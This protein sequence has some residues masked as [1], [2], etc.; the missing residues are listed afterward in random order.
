MKLSTTSKK[1]NKLL[2]SN[3]LV[4]AL[5][6]QQTAASALAQNRAQRLLS[7]QAVT[8]TPQVHRLLQ[9][10]EQQNT[11]GTTN[12]GS[13]TEAG[14]N[15]ENGGNTENAGSTTENT[16]A[17]TTTENTNKIAGYTIKE[18]E[19][20]KWCNKFKKREDLV[21]SETEFTKEIKTVDEKFL[22]TDILKNLFKIVSKQI[23]KGA[24]DP[25]AFKEDG[26]EFGKKAWWLSIN[27]IFAV[28]SALFFVI[29]LLYFTIK[30]F[31]GFFYVIFCC[32]CCPSEL[33][34]DLSIKATDDQ[35]ERVRKA[36]LK[37][38][39]EQRI[40]SLSNP[41]CNCFIAVTSTLI[42]TSIIVLGFFWHQNVTKSLEGVNKTDCMFNLAVSDLRHG[43]KTSDTTF[44]GIG[45]VQYAFGKLEE[46]LK[47]ITTPNTLQQKVK[48]SDV[49]NLFDSLKAYYNDVKGES[50]PSAA[51]NN[52]QVVPDIVFIQNHLILPYIGAEAN[53]LGSA[54]KEIDTMAGKLNE[55][56][57][58]NADQ[59][60]T[61]ITALLKEINKIDKEIEKALDNYKEHAKINDH[62]AQRELIILA[63]VSSIAIV[64]IL[65]L[66]MMILSL[67]NK[68]T[69]YLVIFEAILSLVKMLLA[70][71]LNLLAFA[72]LVSA[73]LMINGCVI[74]KQNLDQTTSI[75]E[76]F[77]EPIVTKIV[78]TC[79]AADGSGN[80]NNIV[81]LSTADKGI[82]QLNQVVDALNINL[83]A[84]NITT[85]ES[86]SLTVYK[87]HLEKLRTFELPAFTQN[88]DDSPEKL[89]QRV[90][91][92][93]S[94]DCVK[95][96]WSVFAGR[97]PE[98][99]PASTTTSQV[100][101]KL[102]ENFCI[103]TTPLGWNTNLNQRY[104]PNWGANPACVGQAVDTQFKTLLVCTT[105]TEALMAKLSAKVDE[106]GGPKE[107]F[108]TVYGGLK[109]GETEFKELRAK[110]EDTI[111]F[112]N[113]LQ[114]DLK[115]SLN[116]KIIRTQLTNLVGNACVKFGK[117][118]VIQAIFLAAIGPLMTILSCCICCTFVQS[119]EKKCLDELKQAQIAD[120]TA[121]GDRANAYRDRNAGDTEAR[122]IL[123]GKT[124]GRGGNP[125]YK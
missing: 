31:C 91:E 7:T 27:A 89:V 74:F 98:T 2:L 33:R 67:N 12:T 118:Y 105:A 97:C 55:Y 76:Y 28:L 53:A 77:D 124:R 36:K 73:I 3:L 45:G 20:P 17:A 93:G 99:Y 112:V 49:D 66:L 56:V 63:V 10:N 108:Q 123:D 121:G 1:R 113:A 101:E 125:G 42:V 58:G 4:A 114:K 24:I 96:R 87:A 92:G 86:P 122:R 59:L 37:V 95:D 69:G 79:I 40:L 50:V 8:N 22:F 70:V 72:F 9:E 85:E 88:E 43:V 102:D 51:D 61:G 106:V 111:D 5:L 15:T 117:P 90:N 60:Q 103:V 119:N 62:K 80:L 109:A 48:V 34:Q 75:S 14:T 11:E 71:V 100:Q 13:G 81:D 19:L 32:C 44:I 47:T 54:V 104:Q 65:F 25:E 84:L 107:S 116:C 16:E 30:L 57:A 94:L 39:R 21:I 6:L 120:G 82:N 110:L 46:G 38:K 26:T 68:C 23:E 115:A 78:D 64:M 83:S 18:P 41:C 35:K 29:M 52:K